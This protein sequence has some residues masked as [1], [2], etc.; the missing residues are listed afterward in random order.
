VEDDLQSVSSLG[1][2]RHLARYLPRRGG[3]RR[4]RRE[5][6]GRVDRTG[7]SRRGRRAWRSKKN[8]IGRSRGGFS[9]KIHA[10]VDLKG[11]P[12]EVIITPGQQHDCTVADKLIDF[13]AGKACLADG[14]YDTNAILQELEFRELE[15]VIPS[16]EDRS[17]K[18]R[19]NR[20]LYKKRYLVELFFHKLKRFRRVAT[21]YEKTAACYLAFI[22]LACACLW[23]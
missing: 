13:I 22:S 19:L 10:I 7:T 16:G 11:R 5:H 8:E 23:I 15:A 1:E 4:R 14:S 9:T 17:T 12:L 6:S 20:N 21:R 18:R 3:H 2:A